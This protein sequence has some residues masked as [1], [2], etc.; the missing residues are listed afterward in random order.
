MKRLLLLTI[1]MA[2][3][4]L[5]LSAGTSEEETPPNLPPVVRKANVVGTIVKHY[6]TR[7]N[8]VVN[9]R[10]EKV[11]DFEG[12]LPV[13]DSRNGETPFHRYERVT[14]CSAKIGEQP[15]VLMVHGML[16][17]TK[18][19]RGTAREGD[20]KAVSLLM[21]TLDEAT[22]QPKLPMLNNYFGTRNLQD[23]SFF[24]YLNHDWSGLNESEE[25][26]SLEAEITDTVS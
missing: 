6:I 10:T 25:L 21:G 1:L 14:R 16:A 24:I 2:S 23:S 17:L 5:S 8:G 11:C 9:S 22:F 13:Y 12:E 7:S 18:V 4:P 20:M 3:L 19:G 26:F 15:V